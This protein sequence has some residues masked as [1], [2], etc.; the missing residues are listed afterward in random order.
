MHFER[1]LKV[2]DTLTLPPKVQKSV[3]IIRSCEV[4]VSITRPKMAALTAS[5]PIMSSLFNVSSNSF[6]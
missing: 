2:T 5:V 1:E 3:Q 6:G 4:K